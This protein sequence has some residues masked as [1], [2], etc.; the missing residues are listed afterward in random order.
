[1]RIRKFGRRAGVTWSYR[2]AFLRGTIREHHKQILTKAVSA[3][4]AV[5]VEKRE[6]SSNTFAVDRASLTELKNAVREFQRRIAKIASG[7]QKD[8]VYILGVQ[9]FPVVEA[10]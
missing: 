9:L 7:G 5:P 4:D 6:F 10:E 3:I 2:A 8:A 1:M